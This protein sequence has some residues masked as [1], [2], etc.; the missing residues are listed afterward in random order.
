MP[1]L[2]DGGSAFP[3]IKVERK[4]PHGTSGTVEE[5]SVPTSGMSL[6]DWFAGQALANLCKSAAFD[7]SIGGCNAA[8]V[9]R[10]YKM[11][12]LMLTERNK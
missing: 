5:I 2:K 9:E 6:R 7:Y 4:Q 10:A 1:T 8:L 3:S 11:A 12:D